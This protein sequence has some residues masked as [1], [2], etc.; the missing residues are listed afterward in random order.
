MFSDI[1]TARIFTS[2]PRDFQC[3]DSMESSDTV[4]VWQIW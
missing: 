1:P 2:E 3:S 4:K